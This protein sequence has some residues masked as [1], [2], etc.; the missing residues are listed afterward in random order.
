MSEYQGVLKQFKEM[1]VDNEGM[2]RSLQ[3][4]GKEIQ[5]LEKLLVEGESK[6]FSFTVFKKINLGMMQ[7]KRQLTMRRNCLGDYVIELE[8]NVMDRK[9]I[10]VRNVTDVEPDLQ[11][12]QAFTI[13]LKENTLLGTRLREVLFSEDRMRVLKN[14]KNFLRLARQEQEVNT[15]YRPVSYNR[16]FLNMIRHH[17]VG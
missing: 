4:K 11:N 16:G 5:R 3:R 8:N 6:A 13:V 9:I 10:Q 2:R 15:E 14:L 1:D 7:E 12:P 17:F